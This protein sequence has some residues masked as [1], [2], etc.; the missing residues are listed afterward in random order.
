MS[1]IDGWNTKRFDEFGDLF[2]GA[3]PSTSDSSYWDGDIVWITPA[4]LSGLS[5]RH[6]RSSAKKITL[7]G[8]DACSTHLMP[9]GSVVMSSRAPI[10]YVALPTVPFCTNQGCKTIRLREGYDPDFTYF[11]ILFNVKKIQDLGEGTTFAEVS[12]TALAGVELEFPTCTDEQAK[13]ADVLSTVDHFIESSEVLI[14]KQ[15][16]IKLGLMQELLTFGVDKHGRVRSE[17]THKF[18]NS[19]AG[20]MP[21]EWKI[22]SVGELFE[23]RR[24]RGRRGLP[25]MSIV[26]NDGLVERSSVERRVTSNLPPEAHALV[27]KGDIAYNM[28]RMWQGVLGR[29]EMDCLVSPAYVVL[30]P[31]D[32]INSHFAEWLFR[33]E[34]SV[35]KFRRSSRGVVD[36]RLRLYAQDLFSIEFAIP[37]S[38]D[39][40][41]AIADRLEAIR[42]EISKETALLKKMRRLRTGLMQDLLT[43]QKRVTPLLGANRRSAMQGS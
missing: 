36:D 19:L 30:K 2:S 22:A 13:I 3:T 25:V 40:Q 21:E 8:L 5:S 33:D 4:D 18:K 42:A 7:K 32:T 31:K 12:K 43:G 34:R 29:A 26:M 15:Q 14:S 38:L 37:K 6:I 28:M 41:Q 23:S 11:N 20:R 10:G 39:E 17:K 24:E 16:R 35:L 27:V 9:V 1:E